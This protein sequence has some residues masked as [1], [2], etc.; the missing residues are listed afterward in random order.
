MNLEPIQ[1]STFTILQISEKN[2]KPSCDCPS[3]CPWETLLLLQLSNLP[4]LK[5]EQQWQEGCR[6]WS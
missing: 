2:P 4:Q 5:G 3:L 1:N 6:F